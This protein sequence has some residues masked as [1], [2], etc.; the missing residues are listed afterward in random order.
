MCGL[1]VDRSNGLEVGGDKDVSESQNNLRAVTLAPSVSAAC[2][3]ANT[4]WV[5]LRAFWS[6]PGDQRS[7]AVTRSASQGFSQGE[8]SNDRI[9]TAAK[10]NYMLLSCH[11]LVGPANSKS[12]FTLVLGTDM[13]KEK[14]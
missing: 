11:Q 4:T 10:D 8:P 1:C 13:R 7:Y 5:L 12:S 14:L 2:P 9:A 6:K 3:N